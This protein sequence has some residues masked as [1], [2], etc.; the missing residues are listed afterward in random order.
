MQKLQWKLYHP[1]NSWS[2]SKH[3][4]IWNQ[5][6]SNGMQSFWLQTLLHVPVKMTRLRH[7]I[8]LTIC[9][10]ILYVHYSY[11]ST[12]FW[13]APFFLSNFK[14][15]Q[16]P[17]VAWQPSSNGVFTRITLQL[18]SLANGIN[19]AKYAKY[20]RSEKYPPNTAAADSDGQWNKRGII[21][22]IRS[23]VRQLLILCQQT[24]P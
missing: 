18:Q 23:A 15:F 5:R 7:N 16:K 12:I 2:Q 13:H 20:T 10:H 17:C 3:Q 8:Q 22:N 19:V 1:R 11:I 4:S 24:N 6:P 14:S 9:W 21:C